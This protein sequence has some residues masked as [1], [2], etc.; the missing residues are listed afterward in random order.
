[1]LKSWLNA[2]KSGEQ[3]VVYDCLMSNSLATI[4]AV[5]SISTGLALD[6]SLET[7]A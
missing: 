6:I 2:M 4:L 1:M 3:C 5:E 7:L